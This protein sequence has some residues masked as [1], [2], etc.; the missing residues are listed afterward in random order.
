[1]AK[2][3]DLTG[4]RFG[5]LKV[6]R[7]D[8]HS[9]SGKIVWKC[10]CDCGNQVTVIGSNLRKGTT[11]S[12]GCY[13]RERHTIHGECESRLYQIWHGMMQ[14]CN[15]HRSKVYSDYGGRGIMV[16]EEWHDFAKFR[17]WAMV[18]GYDESAEQWKCTLDRR[19]NDGN[20]CPENCRWVTYK[21]QGLN[22][23][24]NNRITFNGETMTLTEWADKIGIKR[25]TLCTRLKTY[26]WPV[27]RALTE[28]V[29]R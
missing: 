16:C 28:P 11:Q 20:Y 25:S 13:C 4:M 17:E 27:E 19:D 21:E 29:S 24:A 2:F 1:M 9:G 26:G 8:G 14:R 7:K 23:R 12:C 15:S 6:L 10:L 5:R 22:T 18:N 3:V